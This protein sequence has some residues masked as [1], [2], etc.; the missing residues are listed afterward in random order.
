[1]NDLTAGLFI[2]SDGSVKELE[3]TILHKM[4]VA[5]GMELKPAD[6]DAVA[7]SALTEH[8]RMDC[9]LVVI[10]WSLAENATAWHF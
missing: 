5:S 8:F 2:W 1:V 10:A 6:V 7:A 4:A 9:G 3:R